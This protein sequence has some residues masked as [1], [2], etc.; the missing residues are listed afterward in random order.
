MKRILIAVFIVMVAITAFAGGQTDTAEEGKVLKFWDMQ[1]GPADTYPVTAQKLCD[2]FS[3]ANPGVKVEYQ[4]IPWDNFYQTFLTAIKSGAA[5]DVSTGGFGMHEVFAQMGEILYVDSVVE[6]YKADGRVDDFPQGFLELHTYE[7]KQV[8]IPYMTAIFTH[9][10]RTDMFQNAGI[11]T[12]PETWAE[13]LD[14]GRAIK[15]AFDIPFFAINLADA[16]GNNYVLSLLLA[17]DTG[18]LDKNMQP[19]LAGKKA[20]ETYEF[21]ITMFKEELVPKG[22]ATYRTADVEKAYMNGKISAFTQYIPVYVKDDPNVA[23]VT[24]ALPVMRGPSGSKGT[25]TWVNMIGGYQQTKHPE[26]AKKFIGWYADNCYPLFTEGGANA[27]P[28]RKSFMDKYSSTDDP[29]IRGIVRECAD[30]MRNPVYPVDYLYSKF[31][32]IDGE[33][34]L[35]QLGQM[36]FTGETDPV[37]IGQRGVD[38]VQKALAE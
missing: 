10:Y 23:R 38:L 25:L 1:N 19:L 6:E 5:P 11:G 14:A 29:I 16:Q 37:K 17:N 26:E 27:L 12:P 18:V 31:G 34:L 30:Y 8:G 20:I 21:M 13:F 9:F 36:I 35:A 4:S 2:Q 22:M 28:A 3:A 24:D 33:N 15:N 32:Q 7:G